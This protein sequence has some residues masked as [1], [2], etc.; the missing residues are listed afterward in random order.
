MKGLGH[1]GGLVS[2]AAVLTLVASLGDLT[3]FAVQPPPGALVTDIDSGS[4]TAQLD[5]LEWT[6]VRIK[7]SSP[8]ELLQPFRARY[9]SDPW[10]VDGP[11]AEQ[12]LSRRL[13]RV[14]SITVK[15]PVTLALDDE[16]LWEYPWVYFVE[17]GNLRLTPQEVDILREFLLRGGTATF[18]D[19]HGPVEFE[20]LRQQLKLV[21]PD[22]EILKL[23]PEHPVFNCFYQLKDYPQIPGLGSFFNGVTW[24]KGGRQA[25]LYA[26]LDDTG[27]AMA[28][29]NFNTDMGDGWEWSNAE[30]YPGYIQYTAQAYR[31]MIN[32]VVYALT[33]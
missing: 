27:R 11:A 25:G 20:S 30:D 13:G 7:Y 2:C 9:W 17:P 10:V 3:I 1:L 18:D 33:H 8:E 4:P 14:T 6:F 5:G 19:F 31:M 32:E 29:L 26:V 16:R 28:L 15:E 21:F 24:E 23:P 22:R 12:N